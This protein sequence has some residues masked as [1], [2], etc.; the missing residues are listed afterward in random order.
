ML[1]KKLSGKFERSIVKL[2]A[3]GEYRFDAVSAD[4]QTVA[5]ISLLTGP[6]PTDVYANDKMAKL[7][8]D[9]YWLL[10]AKCKRRILVLTNPAMYELCLK[11]RE[12]GR[13]AEE[14]E[15]VDGRLPGSMQSTV[16]SEYGASPVDYGG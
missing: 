8:G 14:I 10:T 9:L 6:M 4:G 12:K 13:I 5:T 1:P 3:G 11:E 16:K 2:K 15:L 7:R